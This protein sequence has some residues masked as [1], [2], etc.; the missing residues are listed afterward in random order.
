VFSD[1]T[2]DFVQF[3][4]NGIDYMAHD[5]RIKTLKE[6]HRVLEP[7]GLF[8]IAT[9]NRDYAYFGKMPWQEGIQWNLNFLKS[10]L[11]ILCYLPRHIRLK[12]HEIY[13]D[14]YAIIN[15]TA[16]GFSLLTY[17]ISVSEQAR[18]LEQAGF[19]GVE[20]WDMTGNVTAQD[21]A[22]PWI[23]YLARRAD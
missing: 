23:H 16:H 10:S 12:S 1:H 7:G 17:Y 11:Y 6:I 19:T 20:S 9:H 8:M 4:F 14:E 5:D 21:S 22:S 15:D 13:T 18:Q 2:F 3:S